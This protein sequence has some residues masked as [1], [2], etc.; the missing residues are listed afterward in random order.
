MG[1]Y[2]EKLNRN[3][4]AP[5]RLAELRNIWIWI[6]LHSGGKILVDFCL[7]WS[8]PSTSSPQYS[9][10]AHQHSPTPWHGFLPLAAEAQTLAKVKGKNDSGG[11]DPL[12][13][14]ALSTSF[15]HM[16]A[17]THSLNTP[18]CL[19]QLEV[20]VLVMTGKPRRWGSCPSSQSW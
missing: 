17:G 5:T 7:G 4:E 6:G 8:L 15:A 16:Q 1:N 20:R 13:R 11:L 14:E 19:A 9:M 12:S 18:R 10:A 2:W 3:Q